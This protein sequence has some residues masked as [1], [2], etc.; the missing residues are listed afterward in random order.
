MKHLVSIIWTF[1]HVLSVVISFIINKSFWWGLL[2]FFMGWFY[3]VY[4]ILSRYAD[5]KQ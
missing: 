4:Y 3:V 5:L 2:H 1:G